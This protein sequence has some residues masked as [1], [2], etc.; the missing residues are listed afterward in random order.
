MCIHLA[1]RLWSLYCGHYGQFGNLV[2]IQANDQITK[3]NKPQSSVQMH[4]GQQHRSADHRL[5]TKKSTAV[6]D[7]QYCD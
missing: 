4:K 2:K 7:T 5:Y 3:R 1:D 6:H